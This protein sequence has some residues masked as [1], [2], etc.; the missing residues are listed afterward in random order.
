MKRI[1]TP[2]NK[3]KTALVF[4]RYG[5]F[6]LVCIV[7]IVLANNLLVQKTDKKVPTAD[8]E[9][10]NLKSCIVKY[11]A[12]DETGSS[13]IGYRFYDS[14]GNVTNRIHFRN[15]S[16]FTKLKAPREAD[17]DHNI[18]E[19]NE[20]AKDY[21][22]TFDVS[23]MSLKARM[24]M[25]QKAGI[26]VPVGI[27]EQVKKIFTTGPNESMS[28]IRNQYLTEV[29]NTSFYGGK[30]SDSLLLE[31]G[32][33]FIINWK[34]EVVRKIETA[35]NTG[36]VCVSSDL[37]FL[38]V[39]SFEGGGF[40][41]E[42]I[43]ARRPY[44]LYDLVQGKKSTIAVGGFIDSYAEGILFEDSLFQFYFGNP[45][46]TTLRVLIDPSQRKVYTRGYKGTDFKN[47][48]TPYFGS[49]TLPDGRKED[50]SLYS[51][52]AF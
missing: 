9:K 32:E 35:E 25:F 38:L 11:N 31:R 26:S 8:E 1:E 13:T 34:E 19:K 45:V 51:T 43:E 17:A 49:L 39:E 24:Q 18:N 50:L 7:A 33:I 6:V 21:F 28:G 48:Q 42:G 3:P 44:C 5:L 15:R 46:D 22:I 23:K 27:L 41:D 20:Y 40:G 36:G 14:L 29:C 52:S 2:S 4:F 47:V 16:S 37:K 10:S 30:N 12:L